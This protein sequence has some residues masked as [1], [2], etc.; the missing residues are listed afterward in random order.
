ML[1]ARDVCTNPC[2]AHSDESASCA[3]QKLVNVV[4]YVLEDVWEFNL[5]RE[6]EFPTRY[7]R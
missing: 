2:H 4:D 3:D 1:N 7:T 6:Y 5:I